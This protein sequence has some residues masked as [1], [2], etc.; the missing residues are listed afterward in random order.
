M[1]IAL[2][3]INVLTLIW[4]KFHDVMMIRIFIFLINFRSFYV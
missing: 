3:A 4:N 1:F 2:K